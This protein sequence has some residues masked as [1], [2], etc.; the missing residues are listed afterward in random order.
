MRPPG[1]LLQQLNSLAEDLMRWNGH[2]GNTSICTATADSNAGCCIV[3]FGQEACKHDFLPETQTHREPVELACG[4]TIS[5][6]PSWQAP[7]FESGRINED[8]AVQNVHRAS[9]GRDFR[10][11]PPAKSH[12][13][14]SSAQ[15]NRQAGAE[16]MNAVPGERVLG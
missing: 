6:Q 5:T 16:S 11:D 2:C 14:L 10:F 1:E 4:N 8:Q 12:Y 15:P 7:V 3:L 9:H 13:E